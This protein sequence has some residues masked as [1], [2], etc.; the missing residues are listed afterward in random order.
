VSVWAGS[1]GPANFSDSAGEI[2]TERQR[3]VMPAWVQLNGNGHYSLASPGTAGY[4]RLIADRP[5]FYRFKG[6]RVQVRTLMIYFNIQE[7][8]GREAEDR[9]VIDAYKAFDW[10]AAQR[11]LTVASK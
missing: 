10:A 2:Y 3:S 5:D 8:A 4:E 11:M 7:Y 6:S 9:A 1:G